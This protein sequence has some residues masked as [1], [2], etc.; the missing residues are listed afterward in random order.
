MSR[1][2]SSAPQA[3]RPISRGRAA[4]NAADWRARGSSKPVPDEPTDVSP[5]LRSGYR[6]TRVR[7]A[8]RRPCTRICTPSA[9]PIQVTSVPARPDFST[10]PASA[11]SWSVVTDSQDPQPA[12]VRDRIC[13]RGAVC[14]ASQRNATIEW[15]DV[16][17]RCVSQRCGPSGRRCLSSNGRCNDC[18]SDPACVDSI[19][20]PADPS[21]PAG[22]RLRLVTAA[23]AVRPALPAAIFNSARRPVGFSVTSL[24]P[25]TLACYPKRLCRIVDPGSVSLAPRA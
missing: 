20:A 3:R 18:T 22:A 14:P 5:G 1:S 25:V 16:G 4:P 10:E 11:T 13:R 23:T 7:P 8:G 2:D 15:V 9:R 19:K 24:T 21:S 17:S 6:S 12:A